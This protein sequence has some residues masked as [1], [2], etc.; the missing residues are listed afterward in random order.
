M[1]NDPSVEVEVLRKQLEAERGLREA[2][3][4]ENERLQAQVEAYAEDMAALFQEQHGRGHG[5]SAEVAEL[6]A[7]LADEAAQRQ[8]ATSL[9][10]RAVQ[11]TRQLSE[12]LVSYGKELSQAYREG[13]RAGSGPMPWW[14]RPLALVPLA[15]TAGLLL[16]A[17]TYASLVP[18][19][20]PALLDSGALYGPALPPELARQP[21]V[22][23]ASQGQLQPLG[24]GG[25]A[26][27]A[28]NAAQLAAT[29]AAAALGSGATTSTNGTP[30]IGAGVVGPTSATPADPAAA[31]ATAAAAAALGQAPPSGAPADHA[32]A[33]ATGPIPSVGPGDLAP[34]IVALRATGTALAGAATAAAARTPPGATAT[35]TTAIEQLTPDPGPKERC[36]FE[37][38][39]PPMPA[40]GTYDIL[41]QQHNRADVVVLWSQAAG[42]V[43]LYALPPGATTGGQPVASG[44]AGAGRDVVA[45]AQAAGAYRAHLQ[46]QADQPID[47]T[48]VALF[49]DDKS[50]CLPKPS[51]A[52]GD[53]ATVPPLE[54]A[55]TL[56]PST[57]TPPAA[58]V[59][60]ATPTP[61]EASTVSAPAAGAPTATVPAPVP[62]GASTAAAVA[63]PTDAPTAASP[64]PS[65]TPARPT[66]TTVPSTP[67]ATATPVKPYLDCAPYLRGPSGYLETRPIVWT[68]AARTVLGSLPV[69]AFLRAPS[70][71]VASAAF[72]VTP[73]RPSRQLPLSGFGQYHFWMEAD[74]ADL[75]PDCSWDFQHDRYT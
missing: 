48:R 10:R 45:R 63:S 58:P 17:G 73:D 41:F 19:P 21:G 15:T 60:T 46:S 32:S 42:E 64:A 2:A 23:V 40:G 4:A 56:P 70:G 33:I 9:H 59:P 54:P 37:V 35:P 47:E 53:T 5:L 43:A 44:S 28:P 1:P 26:Q 22:L 12:Q 25:A 16:G 71:S 66:A 13:V 14:R 62:T 39:V 51:G 75:D 27:V 8:V 61:R 36:R 74:G 20:T 3:D 18:T 49:F 6:R 72:T 7:Q 55:P 67:S 57:S 68:D 65:P 34:T 31:A 24:P 52:S 38:V 30:V 50:I 69:R 29:A 11:Q